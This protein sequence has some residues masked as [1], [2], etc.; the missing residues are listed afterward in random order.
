M[1]ER[2]YYTLSQAAVLLGCSADDV[3]HQGVKGKLDIH[4]LLANW[5]VKGVDRVSGRHIEFDMFPKPL[6]KKLHRNCLAKFEAN[7]ETA[8]VMLAREFI[9]TYNYRDPLAVHCEFWE[10]DTQTSLWRYRIGDTIFLLSRPDVI[11]LS[12]TELTAAQQRGID[13]DLIYPPPIRLNECVMVVMAEDL[14]Q[15]QATP[16]DGRVSDTAHGKKTKLEKQ[17]DAI[18]E[19]ISQKNF[20]PLEI[21]DGEKG[22]IRL[23]CEAEYKLLFDGETSFDN[24][25]KDGKHLFRMANHA[26]YAKRS[27][28]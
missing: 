12:V 6:T 17:R 20:K 26:S 25:W 8:A 11:Y 19:V 24:A 2:D 22:T 15:L 3:I 16:I 10:Y 27:K 9:Y 1:L 21:P 18:L 23:I 14:K 5:N 4:I 7:Q 13:I 28:Q